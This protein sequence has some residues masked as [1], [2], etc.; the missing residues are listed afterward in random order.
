MN[1]LGIVWVGNRVSSVLLVII[2]CVHLFFI[3]FYLSFVGF[4]LSKMES[5]SIGKF[6]FYGLSKHP[7]KRNFQS[8]SS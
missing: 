7:L 3:V 4:I 6:N 2:G 1:Q 5:G 8:E